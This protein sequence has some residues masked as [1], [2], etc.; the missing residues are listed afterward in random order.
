[1]SSAVSG[2]A[3]DRYGEAR[4]SFHGECR[5]SGHWQWG[6]DRTSD[7]RWAAAPHDGDTALAGHGQHG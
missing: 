5:F 4:K 7:Y 6:D 3:E 2:F 1:M